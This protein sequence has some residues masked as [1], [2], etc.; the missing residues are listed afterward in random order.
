MKK[1]L[2]NALCFLLILAVFGFLDHTHA[3]SAPLIIPLTPDLQGLPPGKTGA[4]IRYGFELLANTPDYIGP[5]GSVGPYTKSRMSCRNCHLDVGMRPLGN[6]WLDTHA[7]YPQYRDRE[8]MVQTL[9][10]RTNA[11]IVHNLQGKPLPE[12]G[13]EMKAILLYYRWLGRDRP[14]LAKDPNQRM[15][16]LPLLSRAAN[17]STGKEIFTNR[18]SSCHGNDGQGRLSV[19]KLTYIYPPLWGKESFTMGASLSR[20]SLMAKFIKGNMPYGV[21]ATNPGLSD[22]ESWDV[23]SYLLSQS[24]PAWIGGRAFPN[25]AEKPFDF[26]FGPYADQFSQQQH[27]LGPFQPI[28]DFWSVT[29]GERAQESSSGI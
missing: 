24:R 2:A 1:Y 28:I 29:Q 10:E 21:S 4:T 7:L 17:P 11:C 5:K 22:E 13:P 15:V 8:G 3:K 9:A 26:P 23:A 16:S 12:N 6:S 18:C 25:L 27:A 19:N 20:L 14:I